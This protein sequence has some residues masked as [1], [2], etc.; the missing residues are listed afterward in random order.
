MQGQ[1]DQLARLAGKA[2]G[3]SREG[4]MGVQRQLLDLQEQQGVVQNTLLQIL[5]MLA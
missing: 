2:P 4:D 5:N 1:V 3:L